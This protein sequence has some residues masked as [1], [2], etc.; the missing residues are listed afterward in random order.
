MEA[1]W[2]K[3][4]L[5]FKNPAT[6]SRGTLTSKPAYFII[7]EEGNKKAVGECGLLPGLS[8][9]DK[10]NFEEKL[11]W[12]CKNIAVGLAELTDE[13]I[14][15]PSI[16]FA[17]EQ[18]FAQREAA[19]SYKFFNSQFIKGKVGM[20]I[21]G[22]VWMADEAN[23]LK[24]IDEKLTAGY[25]C[26]KMKIGALDW[27]TELKILAGMRK[28]FDSVDLEIRVDANGAYTYREAE[29]VLDQMARLEIHSIEQPIK[30]GQWDEMAALVEE[31][32]VPIALDEELIGVFD[33]KKKRELVREIQPDYL[34]LKPSFLGG[35]KEADSWVKIAE[36]EG[37]DWWATSALESNVGLNAIAQWASTKN[38]R[39]P[40]GLGTGG[41]YTNNFE[42]NLQIKN[43]ALWF[44]G[45]PNVNFNL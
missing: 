38:I 9:D 29:K 30:P 4:D 16:R 45:T 31:S 26:I 39:L 10:P 41:L 36:K 22:L 34:V 19:G 13:L 18:V 33:I 21:N 27:A 25:R 44:D 6:T 1:R 12:A 43:A 23:M 42:S 32:L 7:V 17:L 11:T 14:E 40:Q 5:I 28:R 35:W 24:Q 20:R 37:L 2:I 15:W 3:H 8:Y